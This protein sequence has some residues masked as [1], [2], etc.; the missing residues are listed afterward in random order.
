MKRSFFVLSILAGSLSTLAIDKVMKIGFSKGIKSDSA[1]Y[2][3]VRTELNSLEFE[4]N[5]AA[6]SAMKVE[7]AFEEKRIDVYER[8]KLLQ[9]YNRQIEQYDQRIERYQNMIDLADLRNERDNLTEIINKRI[10]SIDQ[11][12]R[13][14]HNRFE[15]PYESSDRIRIQE[16]NEDSKQNSLGYSSQNSG[17]RQ[18]TISGKSF[19]AKQQ[20]S[21]S[22][23][24][25]MK[26]IEELQNQIILELDRLEETEAK[27]SRVDDKTKKDQEASGQVEI[28][29][30][31]KLVPRNG[32]IVPQT[33]RDA[34]AYFEGFRVEDR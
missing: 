32:N 3:S 22:D 30:D 19:L 21:V 14:I 20:G 24:L 34:L 2:E 28:Q 27:D 5:I 15:I 4:K 13:V 6:E 16:L 11:R 26:S 1:P 18:T 31:V 33:K 23:Q 25:E 17:S 9:Q 10:V 7:E 29:D 12:L 8:D